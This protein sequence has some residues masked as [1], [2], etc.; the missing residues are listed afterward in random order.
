MMKP[1]DLGRAVDSVLDAFSSPNRYALRPEEVDAVS[2]HDRALV[3][4]H[5]QALHDARSDRNLWPQ[6]TEADLRAI[7]RRR[8]NGQ[9][10]STIRFGKPRTPN[11]S[12]PR[13]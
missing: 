9:R 8:S 1:K 11:G 7:L 5:R 3:E 12:R 13:H 2:E 6:I 10:P 4:R